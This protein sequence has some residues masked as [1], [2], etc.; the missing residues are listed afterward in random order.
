MYVGLHVRKGKG[1]LGCHLQKIYVKLFL[2]QLP[3]T[4]RL[5]TFK[6]VTPLLLTLKVFTL[7]KSLE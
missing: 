1:D 2:C 5:L 4:L 7:A 6:H 3:L